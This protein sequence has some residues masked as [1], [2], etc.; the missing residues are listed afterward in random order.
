MKR[1]LNT[2]LKR[3]KGTLCLEYALLV[4]G[5]VLALTCIPTFF[6]H[7]SS[8]LSNFNETNINNK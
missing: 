7:L 1:V 3:Q 4:A 8:Y 2:S 5:L 6:E